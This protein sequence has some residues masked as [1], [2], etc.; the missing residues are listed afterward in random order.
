MLSYQIELLVITSTATEK[1][2]NYF[3]DILKCFIQI[4]LQITLI[5]RLV[6]H[7]TLL[8]IKEV[9]CMKGQTI[10]RKREENEVSLQRYHIFLDS[11]ITE[12]M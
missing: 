3:K 12:F 9:L 8:G 2:C 10:E 4:T 1:D 7:K 5:E 6:M 11:Y